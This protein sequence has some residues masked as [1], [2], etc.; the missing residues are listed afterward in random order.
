MASANSSPLLE[1]PDELLEM[2]AEE[3]DWHGFKSLRLASRDVAERLVS[4]LA[5]RCFRYLHYMMMDRQ[6]LETLVQVTA[7]PI[8]GRSIK[9]L[10]LNVAKIA[11]E[12]EEEKQIR[13]EIWEEEHLRMQLGATSASDVARS[14]L[15]ITMPHVPA[16]ER[17]LRVM[18]RTHKRRVDEAL[19]EFKH[20]ITGD[21]PV[22]FLTRIL[23]NLK[24]H[25]NTPKIFTH[26]SRDFSI[27][28]RP[29][30]WKRLTRLVGNHGLVNTPRT[31]LPYLVLYKALCLSQYPVRELKMGNTNRSYVDNDTI[32]TMEPRLPCFQHLKFLRLALTSPMG[33]NDAFLESFGQQTLDRLNRAYKESLHRIHRWLCDAA[34]LEVL[35]L[36][37]PGGS[38]SKIFAD[39]LAIPLADGTAH[40]FQ[41]LRELTRRSSTSE[42]DAARLC[43]KVLID[44]GKAGST[45]HQARRTSAS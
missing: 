21:A 3:T 38:N 10:T 18:E 26:C 5:R 41:K 12:P 17:E 30:S 37:S 1:L 20:F 44:A 15:L 2:I 34:H 16:T 7:H 33:M 19:A 11:G 39:L 42:V 22:D 43:G 24:K 25:N 4:L 6:S 35:A 29:R 8:F 32:T 40:P 45:T 28:E 13:R 23:C 36:K 31:A 27:D 9:V 14:T